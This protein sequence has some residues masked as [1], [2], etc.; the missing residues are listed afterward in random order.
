MTVKGEITTY[1]NVHSTNGN[2]L[3]LP[4]KVTV[5]K[6]LRRN[7]FIGNDILSARVYIVTNDAIIFSKVIG[8]KYNMSRIKNNPNLVTVPFESVVEKQNTISLA[9][10]RREEL[11]HNQ[12]Q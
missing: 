3:S 10:F 1:I 5:I 6:N 8:K 11:K 4:S 7:F 9:S 12:Q 2:S